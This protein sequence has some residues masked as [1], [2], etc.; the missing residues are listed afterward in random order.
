MEKGEAGALGQTT[1]ARLFNHPAF[2]RPPA[3]EKM[4]NAS[5]LLHTVTK[6]TSPSGFRLPDH[7]GQADVGVQAGGRVRAMHAGRLKLG[8]KTRVSYAQCPAV[9]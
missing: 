9:C 8:K 6:A 7:L 5:A 2:P 1:S 4:W 3:P